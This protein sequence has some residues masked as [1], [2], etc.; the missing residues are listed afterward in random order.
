MPKPIS[1]FPHELIFKPTGQRAGCTLQ[2]TKDEES[3]TPEGGERRLFWSVALASKQ[4]KL[5]YE[6]DLKQLP[7]EVHV[8]IYGA[9]PKL[10]EGVADPYPQWGLNLHL[11]RDDGG[12]MSDDKD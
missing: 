3:R 4:L 1:P 5:A 2:I 7:G 6:N 11:C 8:S 12:F 10:P 9:G